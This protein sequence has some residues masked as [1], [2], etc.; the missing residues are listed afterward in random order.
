MTASSPLRSSINVSAL[1]AVALVASFGVQ[2]VAASLVGASQDL[3]TYFIALTIP[4]VVA[5]LLTSTVAAALIPVFA[6]LLA[7]GD[8]PIA[9]STALRT[10]AVAVGTAAGAG[11]VVL[12][13]RSQHRKREVMKVQAKGRANGEQNPAPSPTILQRLDQA[14]RGAQRKEDKEAVHPCLLG[15][16]DPERR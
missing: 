15:V 8:H 9:W 16:P 6:R 11:L 3:D 10:V 2:I 7:S 4:A 5:G 14:D 13:V 1:T 12:R